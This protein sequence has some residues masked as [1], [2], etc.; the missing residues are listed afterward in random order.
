[1]QEAVVPMT[2]SKPWAHV[3]MPVVLS[4]TVTG[5]LKKT[6]W[7]CDNQDPSCPAGYRCLLRGTVCLP[8]DAGL[9]DSALP[10]GL[11]AGGADAGKRVNG[12][13]CTNKDQCDSHYCVDD[14]CC[15][16]ACDGQCSSP[17][18]DSRCSVL[19]CHVLR[20]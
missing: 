2:A 11:E 12:A 7:H 10:A 19:C 3:G 13:K 17:L 4:L 20:F 8:Q 6:I 15:E 9:W 1:M 14:R 5:C 18:P 16:S